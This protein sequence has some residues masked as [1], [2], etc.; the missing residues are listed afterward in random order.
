MT[1]SFDNLDILH[2]WGK[3]LDKYKKYCRGIEQS[4]PIFGE[5]LRKSTRTITNLVLL[6][7]EF[8]RPNKQNASEIYFISQIQLFSVSKKLLTHALTDVGN[9]KH[10]NITS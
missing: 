1:E 6:Y 2:Y 4:R 10:Q 5:R 3:D 8:N 9:A 7:L